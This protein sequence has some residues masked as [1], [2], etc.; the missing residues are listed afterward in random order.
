MASEIKPLCGL[1]RV[2]LAD[3][4]PLPTPFT[5]FVFPTTYCNFKCQYCGHSLG[6]EQMKDKYNFEPENMSMQT[7]SRIIEQSKEFSSNYKMLS[8]TGHGEPL[9]NKELPLMIELAKKANVAERIEIISNASLLNR[10]RSQALVEAG[11]D[12]LRISLQGLSSRKYEQVCGVKLDF[13]ELIDNIRCFYQNKKQCKVFVK[14]MDIALE[15]GEE[16]RFY[17]LFSDISDRMYIERCRPVYDGVDYSQ[18]NTQ[19]II[20]RYG[21][22]HA[23]RMVCP[24]PFYMLGI[25]PNGDVEPCDTIYKPVVVG[26][27]HRESLYS[28]W[29]GANLRQF[30]RM[31]LEK[32]RESNLKCKVCCAPDDVAQPE[33]VLDDAADTIVKRI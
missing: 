14:I 15:H 31:Q 23:K 24:L 19:V 10:E 7:Y 18:N 16:E 1:E 12:I 28:I 8:L 13:D 4:V 26:N 3:A 27:V 32:Q 6:Y 11:L 30:Q 21:R 9:L 29:K 33:D 2:K 17:H 25:F 5:L 22:T 20:D